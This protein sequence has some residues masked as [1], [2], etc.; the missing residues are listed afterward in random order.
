[1]GEPE[2]GLGEQEKGLLGRHAREANGVYRVV[3]R[4]VMQ[5]AWYGGFLCA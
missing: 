5:V 2:G 4:W 3:W 1:M